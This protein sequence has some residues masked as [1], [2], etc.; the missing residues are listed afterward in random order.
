MLAVVDGASPVLP[1]RAS[2]AASCSRMSPRADRA[3][4]RRPTRLQHYTG[5][6]PALSAL[7]DTVRVDR[8]P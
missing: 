3:T 6:T 4:A 7:F 2:S 8:L 5:S 1:S